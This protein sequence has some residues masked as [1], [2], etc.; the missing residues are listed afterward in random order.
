MRFDGLRRGATAVLFGAATVC[1]VA[2]L[3]SAEPPTAAEI[4]SAAKAATSS[5]PSAKPTIIE[6]AAVAEKSAVA[7]I[8]AAAAQN[9]APP[10]DRGLKIFVCGHSFH[11]F[12]AKYYAELAKLAE[13]KDHVTLGA[14]MLGGSSVTQHWDLPDAKNQ[15]KSALK[16][17]QVDVL[18]LSPNWIIPDPAIEKFVDLALANNPQARIVVQMSWTIFDTTLTGERIKSNEERD[19]RTVADLMPAQAGFAALIET[20]VAALNAKLK[21]QSVVISP[22][23]YAVL[24]LRQA[25]IDGKMPGIAKQS[26]L[27]SDSLG[28][29]KPALAALVTYVNFATMYRRSPIGLAPVNVLNGN[30][31]A[32]QHKLLQEIAWKTVTE[33]APSGVPLSTSTAE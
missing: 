30:L 2:R 7:P 4:E 31:T 25:V 19:R 15:C 20:Q 27:F 29:A 33:Y 13:L 28:H 8:P 17:G 23:G 32:E 12:T 1:L 14:Q 9:V 10:I 18:T 22:V 16:T 24:A 6:K 3:T 26:E 11:V 5:T 21:Q